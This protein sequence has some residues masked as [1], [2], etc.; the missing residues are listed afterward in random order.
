MRLV[1]LTLLVLAIGVISTNEVFAEPLD[2]ITTS[3]LNYNG[4]SAN[5]TIAWNPDSSTKNY[6]IGC[7][8]CNPNVVEF[9]TGNN[10]TIN[11]VTPFP[12]GSYALLY[13][14][15]YDSQNNII[16]GKQL[17]VNLNQ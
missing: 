3:V 14:I 7:V 10:M 9:T 15:S 6:K 16:T 13:V 11:H 2:T 12:N 1:L 8:S 17:I 5:V 4:N